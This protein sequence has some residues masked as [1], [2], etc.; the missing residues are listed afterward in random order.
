MFCTFVQ[1]L[2]IQK[3][4]KLSKQIEYVICRKIE[5]G[6]RPAKRKQVIALAKIFKVNPDDFFNSLGCRQD[7]GS[8]ERRKRIGGESVGYCAKE[9]INK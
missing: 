2:T 1:I 8:C 7:Y 5:H 4:I 6:E 9:D 3:S